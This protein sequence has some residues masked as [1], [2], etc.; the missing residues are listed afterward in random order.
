MQKMKRATQV[1]PYM[2]NVTNALATRGVPPTRVPTILVAQDTPIM[3]L[4]GVH[5]SFNCV[6]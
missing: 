3:A 1:T 6:T 4:V 2:A 5:D